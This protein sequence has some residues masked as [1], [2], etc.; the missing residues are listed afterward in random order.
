[1]RFKTDDAFSIK[2]K[3]EITV[4]VV[5]TQV[6]GMDFLYIVHTRAAFAL[7]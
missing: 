5:Q 1:M 2:R 4:D 6:A 3:K 7:R